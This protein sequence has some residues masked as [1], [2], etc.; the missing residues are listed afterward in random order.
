MVRSKR[1]ERERQAERKGERTG[2]WCA[3]PSL[4][5]MMVNVGV[6]SLSLFVVVGVDTECRYTLLK[7]AN[8]SI[9]TYKPYH[10]LNIITMITR[11]NG[12]AQSS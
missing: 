9:F 3:A 1:G 5:F 11:I 6:A 2:S 10:T 8:F 7:N 12:Q 4:P